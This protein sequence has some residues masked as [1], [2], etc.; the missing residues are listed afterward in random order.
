MNWP[1]SQPLGVEQPP[2]AYSPYADP[3]GLGVRTIGCGTF[4]GDLLEVLRL[5]AE[6]GAPASIEPLVRERCGRFAS[7]SLTGLAPVV[8][9]ERAF[10][11]RLEV[12]S[13]QAEGFRLGTV[14]E[15][16]AARQTAPPLDVALTIGDRLL[17]SLASLQAV[18]QTEGAPGHGAIAVDQIVVSESGALTLTDYAFGTTLAA[19][20]WP[21]EQ[22]WRRFRIAM[23]P[24]AGLAR[25][26]HRVDVTQAAVVIASLLAGRLLT[27]EEYPRQL[28]PILAEAVR[29]SCADVDRR[30]GDRLFVWLQ[31]ATELDPRRVFQSAQRAREALH[32]ALG[33]RLSDTEGIGRWLRAARGLPETPAR[34]R[35]AAAS[36]APSEAPSSEAPSPEAAPSEA[37]SPE[38]PSPQTAPSE[39]VRPEA[40]AR[41]RRWLKWS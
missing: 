39:A 8:R 38:A 23:P 11:G 22:L 19:L 34:P 9:V 27:S 12:W 1:A 17:A 6:L 2:P 25:F 37:P 7:A 21:R 18:D 31:A 14:L 16:I 35:P 29:R 28:G 24:A 26:D 3:A 40:G 30:D 15:W 4:S 5:T 32:E 41:I 33:P 10:D 20:Q 13:R 36:S